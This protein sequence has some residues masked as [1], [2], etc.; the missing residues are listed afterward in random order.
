MDRKGILKPQGRRN[1]CCPAI[2]MKAS[3]AFNLRGIGAQGAEAQGR[4]VF[5]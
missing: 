2:L 3:Q 5:W 1:Q 4:R